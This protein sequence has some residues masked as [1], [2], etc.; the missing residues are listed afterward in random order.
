MAKNKVKK[1]P[2]KTR[3]PYKYY[4]NIHY[5]L[6]SGTWAAVIIPII[7]VFGVK[8]NEYFDFL[9][10]T[11]DSVKLTVGCVVAIFLGIIFAVKKA[12]VEEKSKKEYSMIHFVGFV[13]VLWAFLFLF[14]TIIDDMFLITSCEFGGAVAAYLLSIED[15]KIKGKV[16]LYQGAKDEV[17]KEEAKE[18]YKEAKESKKADLL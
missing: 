6:Y 2:L 14:K 16:L 13:A 11:Q 12:K 17:D 3:D 4:R 18:K 1:E 7:A 10:K 5:G 8:W 9:E 15:K